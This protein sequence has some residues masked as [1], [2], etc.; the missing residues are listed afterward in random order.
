MAKVTAPLLGFG[1][2]GQIGKT[3]VYA[4]WR[5]V[6]YAR[7][8]VIPANPNTTSQQ[9]T[10]GVFNWLS[11]FWK[12]LNPAAQ[13]VWTAYAKGKPLTNRNAIIKANLSGLRG[14]D[15]VPATTLDTLQGSPGV[16]GGL[17]YTS[18]VPTDGG[19]HVIDATMTAPTLPTG[20][21]IT[22]AHAVAIKQQDAHTG[23]TYQSFYAADA[24][25]PYVPS[26]NVGAAGTY[27][28]T[29]WF[30]YTKPDGMTAYSPSITNTVVI[31]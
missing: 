5:G 13:A 22:N 10:R 19:G 8:H 23:T 30:E 11:Q 14:T 9:R 1:S 26:P 16:N 15:A 12:E 29:A 28:V 2:S 4:K 7:Q 27:V 24:T 20:W 31:A 18:L 21:A 6:S 17:A 25:T 3:Q